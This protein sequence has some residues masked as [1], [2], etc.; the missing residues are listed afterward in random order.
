MASKPAVGVDWGT[1]GFGI[2][3]LWL[4]ECPS[5][6]WLFLDSIVEG[7]LGAYLASVE[8][9][10]WKD[11]FRIA[12][13]FSYSHRGRQ[14]FKASASNGPAIVTGTGRWVFTLTSILDFA[15][16]WLMVAD[17]FETG[18]L[19]G[20]THALKM[21]ACTN[22]NSPFYAKSSR[23]VAGWPV[24]PDW[25]VGPTFFPTGNTFHPQIGPILKIPAFWRGSLAMFFQPVDLFSGIP[26][27]NEVRLIDKTTGFIYDFIGTGP[28]ELAFSGY[29][30]AMAKTFG[31]TSYDREIHL[32]IKFPADL[33]SSRVVVIPYGLAYLRLLPGGG[34]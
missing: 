2:R 20:T 32:E 5:P 26:V 10:G 9:F 29:T 14:I 34:G 7:L 31:V 4:A 25:Q 3:Q 21:S 30:G 22:P 33:P 17:L 19:K 8:P 12:T 23:C 27:Q 6:P 13:G 11:L 28:A 24:I 16:F 1:L 18:L 15:N